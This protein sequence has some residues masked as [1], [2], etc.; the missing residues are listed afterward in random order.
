MSLKAL[1]DYTFYSRYS[2][3]LPAEKRRETW[4]E[5]V[6]RVFDMHRRKYQSK[7]EQHPEL[8]Q[9][10]EF[11]ETQQ[12]KKRVL[13]A[14][15]AL[16]FG[17]DPI[18]KHEIKIYNCSATH[19]NR[20]RVFQ[21]ALYVLLCGC[22]V[23]FSVQKQHVGC[24]PEITK[25]STETIRYVI[26]DS[27]EGW[28]DAVGALMSSY[29]VKPISGFEQYCNKTVQFDFSKIRLEGSLIAG[30]FKAPG[31]KGLAKT[32]TKAAEVIESRLATTAADDFINKLRPI[33]C[34]D[35]LMH[36][37]DSVLSGGV[38][39]S[40]T[41]ALFS[42]DDIEMA[43]A[44]V[45][46]WRTAN[47]QRARSN[48]S[49]ALLRGS[50]SRA[51]F[52]ALIKS[53]REFGEPGFIWVDNQDVIY[54]P[55]CEIAQLP[56]TRSGAPGWQFC[57]LT[58]ANGRYCT[59]EEAFLQICR[60]SA[61]IG[62]LQA[63]YTDIKYLGPE[64]REIVEREALLGCS[65]TGIMDNPD[66]LLN[67]DIL[68]RGAQEVRNVNVRIAALIGI[69]PA[70]RTTCVKPAGSTS[71][72]LGTASGIHPH[73]AR[74]YIRRVQ[75]NKSEFC[76]SVVEDYNPAAV[77]ESVWSANN[78][79]K[80]ISFLCEVPAG[81][82]IKNQTSALSLLESV[83]SVQQSWVEEGTDVGRCAIPS[84]R[85]NVSNTIVVKDEEWGD[86]ERYIYDNRALFAGV[87]LLPASGDLDYPQVPFATV[88][89]PQELV[90]E[91]G[92][93]S[94]FASGV[95]VD[96][97]KAFDDN[98]WRACD[99]AL[100]PENSIIDTVEKPVY[101]IKRCNKELAAYFLAKEQYDQWFL[102]IDWIR[103]VRQFA[104]RY[105]NGDVRQTTYC[106]KHV[107]LWKLWCDLKR[108]Y[109]DIDWSS[110]TENQQEFVNANKLAAQACAGGACE[111]L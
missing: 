30:Q 38:R 43:T 29:F 77:E 71:C 70:A 46:N 1:S 47:P 72:I 5:S 100:S 93:A 10:I 3:Y 25:R 31:P 27:I 106:L 34:Y 63:G 14:Q 56:V 68:K 110:V 17:G 21:E 67:T 105:F 84:L 24:L 74:R 4:E 59:S 99:C 109:K 86:V 87:S 44:K 39:R 15:R 82:V 16:Q 79:D 18:F 62:T 81:A 90:R 69:N 76:L 57:N 89:S 61:I 96:G 65:I 50:V 53:T 33:D 9:E 54:N 83:K 45:G 107:S 73:H 80:I 108:D 19:I 58:E 28:S 102:K 94:I 8:A 88:L 42:I 2:R 60:A 37:S 104:M 97:L 91:Y 49:A 32:L 26:E 20:P 22:G 98:L 78:T 6:T 92:D 13:A 52:S 75:A 40:A 64:T 51:D 36:I 48:N 35:I 23:G 101:P 41:L 85:H 7:I 66:I 103:R 111:I 55:C 12:K 11:A 95:V